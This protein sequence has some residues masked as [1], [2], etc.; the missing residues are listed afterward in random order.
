[1]DFHCVSKS[2][3]LLQIELVIYALRF[4][5]NIRYSL[6]YFVV[7]IRNSLFICG[8]SLFMFGIRNSLFISPF[9][10]H[11]R[12][13]HALFEVVF[14]IAQFCAITKSESSSITRAPFITDKFIR[15]E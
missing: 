6:R 5:P 12:Y 15:K 14:Q 2:Q 1:M 13:S 10:I 7:H 8:I 4:L 3:R 11:Y 9:V